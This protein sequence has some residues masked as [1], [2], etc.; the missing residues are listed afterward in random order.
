MIN[1]I[2]SH[3]HFWAKGSAQTAWMDL[4]P[5]A[6]DPQYNLLRHDFLS[7][8]LDLILNKLGIAQAIIVEA[9]DDDIENIAMLAAADDNPR[10]AAIVGWLPLLD[11]QKLTEKLAH[12][13]KFPKFRAIRHLINTEPDA[14]WILNPIVIENLRLAAEIGLASDYIGLTHEHLKNLPKLASQLPGLTI[15]LDHL[16]SPP[17]ASGD[18]EQWSKNLAAAAACPNVY[19]KI[20]GLDNAADW[21]NWKFEDLATPLEHEFDCFGSARLMYGSNWPVT[22]LSGGYEKYWSAINQWL[23]GHDAID[24]TN[25]LQTTAQKAYK[26]YNH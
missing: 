8:D 26:L 20:S 10:I 24:R 17:I 22:N 11:R 2:D 6:S 25:I 23:D 5:Y 3:I 13:A 12:Y 9:I 21:D 19:A 4:E 15:I 1:I 14:D 7:Q 16:N 18:L